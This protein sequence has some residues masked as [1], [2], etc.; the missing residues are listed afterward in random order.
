[1]LKKVVD[2][3]FDT[4]DTDFE[5]FLTET[6]QCSIQNIKTKPKENENNQLRHLWQHFEA[7]FDDFLAFGKREW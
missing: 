3:F 5:G 4:G 2:K 6:N 7:V 1:M